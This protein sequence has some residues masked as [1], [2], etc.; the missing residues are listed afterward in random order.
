MIC[1]IINPSDAYTLET[2]DFVLGAVA[3]AL[4]GEGQIGLREIGGE[5]RRSPVLFGWDEWLEENGI[6]DLGAYV[7]SR[8]EQLAAVLDTVLIGSPKDRAEVAETLALLPESERPGWLA[9]RHDRRRTS[10]NDIGAAAQAWAKRLRRK[11]A[12]SKA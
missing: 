7:D 11:A 8:L 5:E 4:I 1:D 12:E 9:K 2:E 10:L 6:P 3:I